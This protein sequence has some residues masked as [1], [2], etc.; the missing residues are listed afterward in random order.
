MKIRIEVDQSISENEI[1]IRCKEVSDDVKSVENAI[2]AALAK[3]EPIIFY[4]DET[5]Y[6]MDIESVLFFETDQ[7]T[8]TAHTEDEVYKVRYK[9]YELEELLPDYFMRISKSTILNTN[10]IYSISKNLT[11]SSIIEFQ[12]TH[13]KAYVSRHY[14]KQLNLRLLEGR[15]GL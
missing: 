2:L 12:N 9:L 6:Y 7:N 13:K 10:K 15:N 4:K 11:A 1:V 5:Q 14:Y 3:T 8:I